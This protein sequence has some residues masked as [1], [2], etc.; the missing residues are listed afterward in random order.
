MAIWHRERDLELVGFN[1]LPLEVVLLQHHEVFDRLAAHPE[2]KGRSHSLQL[3]KLRAK[4]ILHV[5]SGVRGFFPN[6]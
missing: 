1:E 4:V 2:L 6:I 3:E 5:S